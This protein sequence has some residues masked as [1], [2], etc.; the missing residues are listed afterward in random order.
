M[1]SKKASARCLLGTVLSKLRLCCGTAA[2][3]CKSGSGEG[4]SNAGGTASDGTSKLN[5]PILMFK[6]PLTMCL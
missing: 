4:S 6:S 3:W 1:P 5:G 2:K